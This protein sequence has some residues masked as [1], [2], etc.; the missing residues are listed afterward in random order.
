MAQFEFSGDGL[1]MKLSRFESLG[2]LH[3]SPHVTWQQVAGAEAVDNLWPYLRGFRAPGT[4]IPGVIMLGTTRSK[5]GRDFCAVRGNKPGIIVSLGE[6]EFDRWLMTT[7]TI[8]T[9]QFLT[10]EVLRQA[11]FNP[12]GA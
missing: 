8:K 6:G 5:A 10:K 2:G 9:A 4:G 12:A 11:R 3:S 7:D 1:T